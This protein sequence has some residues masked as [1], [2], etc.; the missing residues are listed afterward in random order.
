M[1]FLLLITT[2]HYD[3][4]LTLWIIRFTFSISWCA[5]TGEAWISASLGAAMC[6]V[7]PPPSPLWVQSG[8]QEPYAHRCQPLAPDVRRHMTPHANVLLLTSVHCEGSVWALIA[9]W[10]HASG[11][12][13]RLLPPLKTQRDVGGIP[14]LPMAIKTTR[15]HIL[16]HPSDLNTLAL[17][18]FFWGLR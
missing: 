6:N 8:G 2:L 13:R 4:C 17:T 11:H 16:P 9:K 18:D 5:F 15:G 1:F 12:W 7:A 3:S 14:W 10:R